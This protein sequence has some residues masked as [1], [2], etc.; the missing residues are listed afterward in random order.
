MPWRLPRLHILSIPDRDELVLDCVP[1]DAKA[2]QA[3]RQVET[4]G[5]GGAWIQI[6]HSTL[7]L[8]GRLVRMAVNHR[9]EASCRRVEI[10]I[11]ETMHDVQ[12]HAAGRDDIGQR[13]CAG[14]GL[15]IHV[16]PHRRDWRDGT[17]PVEDVGAANI[18][19]MHDEVAAPQRRKRLFT[20]AAMRVG[21]H[22]DGHR[23]VEP[24]R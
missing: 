24:T 3:D 8:D 21:D 10:E 7:H 9:G 23:H 19:G 16:S 15:D 4:F 20:E 22:A 14:P 11:L 1:F 5:P 18:A 13:Q 12:V 17:Q 2:G 6:E